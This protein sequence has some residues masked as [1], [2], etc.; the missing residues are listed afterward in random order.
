MSTLESVAADLLR[1][2]QT[3]L[4]SFDEDYRTTPESIRS[5]PALKFQKRELSEL[6]AK[7]DRKF[8]QIRE[9]ADILDPKKAD[10][11]NLNDVVRQVRSAKGFYRS[12]M[13]SID[14][15]I[16][17]MTKE[18]ETRPS[19]PEPPQPNS[20]TSFTVPPCDMPT[21]SGDFKSW[22]SFR[23]L[24]KAIYGNNTRLSEVEKLFHLKQKTS[25][26]AKEIVDNAPLTND[27]FLIAWNQ[28]TSQYE[29]RRMQINA[30]L[31][32]L[33]NLPLVSTMCSASIRK[34]QR[35][36]NCCIAN[37]NSLDIDTDQWD[38]IL[39]YLCTSKLPRETRRE[40]EKSLPDC[41]E[42]PSW[43]D[44]DVFL[45]NTFKE[46]TSVN[47][48]QDLDTNPNQHTKPKHFQEVKT[49]YDRRGKTFH[50][51][52]H[53]PTASSQSRNKRQNE[54]KLSNSTQSNTLTPNPQNKPDGSVCKLCDGNHT[55]RESIG[56]VIQGC[57]S[58]FTCRYCGGRHNSLLHKPN[59][60]INPQIDDN[61]ASSSNTVQSFSTQTQSS[62]P[63]PIDDRT[64][65]LG[66]AVLNVEV[67]GELFP[68]R[69]LIDP[70]SDFS[71]ITD[72][73]RRK[74]HLPT[75]PIVAEISGLNE[76]V[77]ARSNKLCQVSLRSNTHTNFKLNIQ[78]IVVKTL[79]KNL[80]TQ[81]LKPTLIKDL[82][83][84]QLADQKFYESRP[85]DFIIG[86]DFYPQIL[87]SGVRKD[88]LNTLIAQ[89]TEFGWI[90]TGPI[91]NTNNTQPFVS[92][93]SSVM[94]DKV[95]TKFWEIEDVTTQPKV[96]EESFLCEETYMT[97]TRRLPNG[98]Y[99][100]NLPFIY[101][102]VELGN[103]RHVAMAQ[104]LR[105][106]KSLMKKPELKVEY[107]NVLQEYIDLGHMKLIKY[108]PN[109][110][111]NT[112]YYLPHHAVVKLDHVTTKVRVVFNAS[113]KTSNNNSLNDT[114]YT[115]P[116]LQQDLV[117]LILKWRFY[118]IVYNAD[119]TKMYRQIMLNPTHTPFQRI[120]FRK[121]VN[122]PIQDYE[123]QTVTFG[124]NCAKYLAI[125]TL[126][127]L[128]KDI[129]NNHPIA[130][131]ILRNNMYVDDVLAGGN[132]IEE[133]KE[134]QTQL[135][136]ALDS[137]G[138]PLRKWISNSRELLKDLPEEHLLNVDLLNLPES[139]NAK[140]LGIRWNAK[141]DTF[142]FNVPLIERKSA[143]TKR[144]VL[145]D[146][147]RLFD[148]AG[149][150]APIVISAKI[151]MQQI[152]QDNT[153]WD[154]C[155][156][157]L[158]LIKWQK[159]LQFYDNINRIRIPRWINFSP[160]AK[161]EFHGFSDASEKAYSACLYAR[162]T[163][164][165]GPN[166]VTLLFAK[167]RVA[168]IKVI[169]LPKLE[170]CG[171]VLLANMTHNLLTQLNLP[172]HQTYFWTDSSIVLAWLSKQ[173]N[174]WNTFV[175]NR[176]STIIQTVGVENW[177]HVASHDNPADVASRGCTAD[178]L[179]DDGLWWNG[180]SWLK[181]SASQWPTTKKHFITQA[182]AKVSQS[183]TTTVNTHPSLD[184]NTE[185]PD[186]LS[187]FSKLSNA[188]RVMTYV[189]R[190]CDRASCTRNNTIRNDRVILDRNNPQL[191]KERLRLLTTHPSIELDASEIKST[192]DRLIILCQTEYFKNEY[193]CLKR[194]NP[195]PNKSNL[196]TLTPFLDSANIMRANGRLANSNSL[197]YSERHPVLLP[198]GSSFVKLLTQHV[199]LITLH[200]GNQLMLR[201]IRSGYWVPK[202]KNLVSV[203]VN[204]CSPCT[205]YK[206][207]QTT[208]FMAA[209]PPERTQI[210]KPFTNVG[211][212]F[213]GP[214][215]IKA[216]NGR[217]CRITKGYVCVFVCFA[218]KAIH[219]EP[220]SE[221]STQA[222]MAAFARFFSRRG[223]PVAIYSDNGTNFIGA[224]KLLKKERQEFIKQLKSSVI[225][226]SSFQNLTW[227][228]IPPGAP[229]MG[230]LWEAGVKSFKA[231]LKKMNTLKH[232]FEEL[233]TLLA[234]IEGC[235]NSRPLSPSS[236]NPQD[237]NPLTPGHFLIGSPILTPAEP[238]LSNEN[239]TL[240]NRWQK[241]KIQHHNFC[242]RWKD[243]YLKELHKR[244]KWKNPQRQVE[245]NDI[246]IIRQD[247]LPP[248]EWLLG[249]VIKTY[250]GS[251][252]RN[253]VV[254]IRTSS[255]TLTRPITKVVI[256]PT[257]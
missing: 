129:Q 61:Q 188:L 115:G 187:R 35:K 6:W 177:N 144:T 143:Y 127:E 23:D 202:L 41:A 63:I 214:F 87:K 78:A 216:Y 139:N 175:A 86:S 232:T 179:K 28:L 217:A 172:L 119:I 18:N 4:K 240:A 73:L 90:L 181:E 178:E 215:D 219:L 13:I 92:Y 206:N 74:L 168:P 19:L 224:S 103:S 20:S 118:K 128:A 83:D 10:A 203:V 108:N 32:T 68:A 245:T 39:V 247:N 116:T 106:E 255:G 121:S 246:V 21:F 8:T 97:T 117:V 60:K 190:F 40:F 204:K 244:Y 72:K 171:A 248:N 209:L 211:V 104:F 257:S 148:P 89:E 38:P 111:S 183:F 79:T 140:T 30:Q 242:R 100:V 180:P 50:N 34:L 101:P 2:I 126:H 135:I 93:F 76:I 221:L 62:K 46:L 125:R 228:F 11:I 75:T 149:W 130:S 176:V 192:R 195:I 256:L 189:Y 56:H 154:E 220:T 226:A 7:I 157:P 161:I 152:W 64:K 163:P 162:V 110:P 234:R 131:Q 82:E 94:L 218:T 151:I 158:T 81:S 150:L 14:E 253:R 170:L 166:S 99:Q 15:S 155:L 174:S 205:R 53:D 141:E 134:G 59:S 212:D 51:V 132:T 227:H 65:L 167:T 250:T 27:G 254:D 238:D 186:I 98:R 16:E 153:A 194:R 249:R 182:E 146:I 122:E 43:T 200:G 84:I 71:F 112:Q 193:H 231:H 142:F 191:V 184:T 208:Q 169:S 77:S 222:F 58:T 113:S 33:L 136:A 69:A 251:D 45:T 12:S 185:N 239:I 233:A 156:N 36:I 225:S 42:M 26:E 91:Q 67:Q 49:Q 105:N 22:A 70:A 95:L 48:V 199:H 147:A 201:I 235:L 229:H 213:A 123:L 47:D 138:F 96:S 1:Y 133:A 55:L 243:E 109:T 207:R 52:T 9:S 210:D 88:L 17:E 31:K 44:L 237:L 80:P 137:A 173:P 164:I 66:T 159:F 241:L 160:S 197:S 114:L 57:R 24:F 37:L 145:S 25:G 5:L 124:V 29:N 85:I 252:G 54:R 196:L 107:D 165:D 223:C 102:P 198:Y 230:G 3:D 236:E 120:L